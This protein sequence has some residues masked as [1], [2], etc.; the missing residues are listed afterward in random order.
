MNR[1]LRILIRVLAALVAGIAV[2]AGFAVWLVWQGPISLDPIAPLIA[3]ALSRDN[4]INA[5]VDHTLLSLNNDGHIGI[6]ARGVHLSRA[7]SGATLTLDQLNL[8]INLRAAL[9]GVIAPTRIAVTK[10]HL[11]LVREKD[12]SFHLGV[13]NLDAPAAEDWGAKF[14]SNLVKP[15]QGDGTLGDLRQISVEQASLT[16]DDRALGVTWAAQDVD[17]SLSRTNDS[18]AGV[19]AIASGDARF[20]GKY[21]YTV[22]DNSF[23]VRLGFTDLRPALW[24]DASPALAGLAAFDAPFSGELVAVID[25]TQLTLRDA[26]W[27]VSLGAGQIKND[28][29]EGGVLALSGARMQGGYDLA[30]HRLN[31]GLLTVQLAHGGVGA[32]GTVDGV[33]SELLSGSKPPALDLHLILAAEALKVDDLPALWPDNANADT[34][35]WVTQH[36][37]DGTI[38]QLQARLGLHLDLTPGAAEP[39]RLDQLDGTFAF[40]G[41]G[42]EYFRPLAPALNVNGTARFSRTD[43]EFTASS[44]AVGAIKASAA[45]A[46]F[47]Q[48]DTNDQQAKIDVTAAGP[49]ADA[50]AL[51]D[52]PPF[53]YA[54]GMGIDPKQASGTV[55]TQLSF[56]FPLLRD[57]PLDKVDYSATA[58]LTGVAIGDVVLGRDLSDG[59]LSLKL[60]RNTAQASGTAKLAGVPV[61]L[62]WQEALQAKAPVRTRYDVTATLDA[63]QRRALGVDMFANY[64]GG[65]IGVT[66]T[67]SLNAAKT[68]QAVATIDLSNSTLSLPWFGWTKA[69]NV[70]ATARVT[71]DLADDKVMSVPKA[72]ITGADIDAQAAIGFGADGVDRVIVDHLAIGKSDVHG[73]LTIGD[74]GR[75]TINARGKSLDAS[76]LVKEIDR[77]PD[78]DEPP[79]LTIDAQ[80]DKLILGPGREANHVSAKLSSDGQHWTGASILLGL[81]DKAAATVNFGG[82]IGDGEFK[83]ATDDFGELLRVADIYDNVRG[84]TFGLT[85]K[86]EDRNGERML[87]VDASG[88]DYRVVGAPALARLLSI[89]SLSGAGALL[90][91]QG[92]PFSRLA[93]QVIFTGDLIS[94]DGLRAYG[95]ALGI[96]ASGNIDRVT[97]QMSIAG[98]LVPAY[99][100][101]SVLGNIPVLGNLLLGGEGQGIFAAN[102]RLYGPRDDPKVS[103]NPLSTLAPGVLRNLFL[104]SPGGP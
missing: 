67:Y 60:D 85:G 38:D 9:R 24:A 80:L 41:L 19:F 103:V 47:T 79:P 33:G 35:N 22:A 81:G 93:G 76:A 55:S 52:T 84:G 2:A 3:D 28:L 57:L 68:A 1:V 6:L 56:A 78:Q 100:L 14:V 7:D 29:F 34:R 91:G 96:N 40:S 39:A 51:L 77:R 20:S 53:Y 99:T 89:A 8:E 15:P 18:T 73:S 90:S 21:I 58:N 46:R 88:A 16:V 4:G 32:S 13:G 44:G 17:L 5:T 43:I 66:A 72:S 11:Q 61:S 49:L 87:I 37:H 83:L 12:G 92:I 63:D 36:L 95:G 82:A 31:V 30:R 59:A 86:A 64:I 45:T 10:P 27:D 62:T 74:D 50:L 70:P 71:L 75:W 104:F 94:L 54:R 101:N 65:P 98:T 42:V 48:L 23:V 69:E 25:G 26:T 102:F 97:G